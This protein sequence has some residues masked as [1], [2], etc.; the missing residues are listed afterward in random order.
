ME[1]TNSIKTRYAWVDNIKFACCILVVLGHTFSGLT[2]AGIIK[3]G[4]LF[5][6]FIQ[7]IYTFHVPMFFVCS[8]FLYQKS[9]KVHDVKSWGSNVL[10][11][12]L[13]LGVPYVVFTSVTVLLKNF[14]SDSV[15]N[16]NS[17]G[18]LKTIFI[19]PTAPYWYLYVLFFMFLLVPCVNSRKHALLLLLT[20]LVARVVYLFCVD[21]SVILPYVIG[22]ILGRIIWFTIGMCIAFD[23][24]DL[25]AAYS[26]VLMVAFGVAAIVLC[27]FSFKKYNPDETKQTLIGLLFVFSIIILSHNLQFDFVDKISLKFREYFMP[28]YVMHTIFSAGLRAI[29]LTIESLGRA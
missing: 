6:L 15:N 12:L 4:I 3:D 28:V 25:K 2:Q 1:K 17:A 5:N 9:N 8:G 22:A 26:K 13:N 27:L 14:F 16:Q 19:S 24:I 10:D 23:I 21:G 29:L 11:K 7:S 18:L 20:G